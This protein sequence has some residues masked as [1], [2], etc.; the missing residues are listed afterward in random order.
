MFDGG[1]I[2][3]ENFAKSFELCSKRLLQVFAT[4]E[5]P[6]ICVLDDIQ[7]FAPDERSLWANLITQRKNRLE[8]VLFITLYRTNDLN[9]PP[10]E[11]NLPASMTLRITTLNEN[12]VEQFVNSCFGWHESNKLPLAKSAYLVSFLISETKGNP[13]FLRSLIAELVRVGAIGESC[14]C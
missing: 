11:L 10:S 5:R 4:T 1:A 12:A 14:F 13:F 8:N 7:A 9:A 6:L 2:D 3:W